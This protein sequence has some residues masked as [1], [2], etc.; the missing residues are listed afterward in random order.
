MRRLI[1]VVVV[2][3]AVAAVLGVLAAV[4]GRDRL[5]T[6][7][8]I[9]SLV[10]EDRAQVYV[11][12]MHPDVRSEHPGRCPICGMELVEENGTGQ[13]HA[14]A[15]AARGETASPAVPGVAAP[16]TDESEPR[17]PVTLDTRRQQLLGVRIVEAAVRPIAHQVRAS[18][19]VREDE[20]RQV[21]VNVRIAGWVETLHAD[22]TGLAVRKG[23]VLLTLYSPEL[24][25][26]Q[27]EFLLAL[28]ANR[29]AAGSTAVPEARDLSERMVQAARDR[30]ALW[31]LPAE[32]IDR[33]AAGQPVQRTVEVRAPANG[34]V[35]DKAVVR[36]MRVEPGQTLFRLVDLSRVWVEAD[37]F[38]TE[39]DVLRPGAAA[40]VTV[41]ALPNRRFQARLIFVAPTVDPATRAVRARF[42]LANP[43]G[44]LKPGMFATVEIATA[45]R[46]VVTVSADAV[47]DTGRRQ[48]VFLAE[49]EGRFTPRDVKVGRRSDGHVEV[50]EGLTAGERVAASALFFLDSES[51]LRAA[52]QGYTSDAGEAASAPAADGQAL[53]VTLTSEPD[54][55]RAGTV[56][57]VAGV[58]T[59]D[60]QP[61][62]DA[63]VAVALFMPAMPSMNMPAM[64]SDG[65]LSH[66]GAGQ[67]RGRVE[68]L[69]SGRWDATVT[70]TQ[71]GRVVATRNVSLNA[72]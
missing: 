31:D 28:Q 4:T 6:M 21:D 2:L 60:G 25:A 26:A 22:F 24:V 16:P 64:R 33:I 3:A 36:G 12:P 51:Q 70:V 19:L 55:P 14:A 23:D 56:T 57:F 49:G 27:Q 35:V 42:E 63:E 53:R 8:V 30:L 17:A 45:S 7:P 59:A 58:T 20:T 1:I 62:T 29:Q 34:I 71:A 15:H 52:L 67:Y 32:E 54:P 41:D 48:L 72:R 18:G 39:L 43:G 69:M 9:G 40:T 5:G 68:V 13:A 47:V 66:A 37:V 11:C 44:A 10:A 46:A 38:E 65:R 61:V 50:L